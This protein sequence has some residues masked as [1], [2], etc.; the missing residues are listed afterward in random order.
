MASS[1]PLAFLGFDA[2]E[3]TLVQ[4]GL[5]EGWLPTTARLLETGRCADLSPVPSGFY[6]T[7]WSS[8]VTG[9]DVGDHQAVLD[10]KLE[11]GSYRI[12]DVPA[13]SMQRPPFWRYLSDAGIRSTVVGAYSASIV[14][15][16]LGTQVQG[17]GS[18]DPYY[19]K[20]GDVEFDPP[21]VEE[22]LRRVV[23]R[24][25]ALYRVSAPRSSSEYRGYRDRILA[26][27][28]EETRGLAA[29]IDGTDWDFFFGSYG[30]PHQAGHLLWHLGDPDHA[31]HDPEASADVRNALVTIYR[32]VDAGLGHLIERLPEECRVFVL[33]PHGMGP[34][35]VDDPIEPILE[36]GG[37]LVRRS[38]LAS[39]GFRQQSLRTAWALGRRVVPTRLRVAAQSRLRNRVRAAMP[40]AHVD[41]QRT[42]AFAL[43]SDMTSYVRINLAGRE[44]EGIVRPGE[45]YDRLCDDLSRTLGAIT[46]ADSGL[47]AVERVV[48]SEEYFGR[49]VEGGLPD[50]CVVWAEREPARRLHLPEHG[51]VEAPRTD[52]RTGQHRHMGLIVGAGPGIPPS[53]E[54]GTGGLLDVAPT[55]LA[56][57]GVDQ[58]PQLP[59]QPIRSFTGA[60]P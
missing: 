18:I 43:P 25:Q 24:R 14:P 40:L 16:F 12:V 38:G 32:A 45:E 10:R 50:I 13:S 17:W 20:F 59:G 6:N 54:R 48:R 51:T 15:S 53:R 19:A 46:H 58:P 33:T 8:L 11:S 29:L 42:T 57:L 22:L 52:P 9:T 2:A 27:I 35:Y 23:P 36:L 31:A 47:P 34:S 4:R 3:P 39:T 55:A 37:W 44:P 41:W 28:D 49:P 7:S 26:S 1:P 5:E 21:E 56:L 30:E 60:D